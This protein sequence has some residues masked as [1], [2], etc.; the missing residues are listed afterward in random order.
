VTGNAILL[1][2]SADGIARG[3]P[4]S[5]ALAAVTIFFV[6][7]LGLRSPRLGALAMI[8]N[9]V[10]VLVFFGLL[11]LGA[12]PLSLPTSLIGCVA[13]GIAI[14]DTV[15]YLVRYRAERQTGASPELAIVRCSQFI[16]RPIA[17]TSVV[18]V[19][20][21]LVIALSDFAT[22]REFGVLSAATMGICLVN[23]LILLPAL[24]VRFRV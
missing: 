23:D 5:V 6:I 1:A 19:A 18:L 24:L 15:H 11:G 22:L 12:A 20:G 2:R 21:F 7:A 14:D 17:V 9:L 13:L 4:Q 16:G 8:P 3:Q 10:P